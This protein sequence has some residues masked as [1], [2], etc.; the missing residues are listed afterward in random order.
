VFVLLVLSERLVVK[1]C[2]ASERDQLPVQEPGSQRLIGPNR[3]AQGQLQLTH[4]HTQTQTLTLFHLK[5]SSVRM[6]YE[7]R[8]YIYVNNATALINCAYYDK[9]HIFRFCNKSFS[10][11]CFVNKLRLG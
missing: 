2:R 9:V 1:Q 5:S 3:T 11:F 6:K 8:A 10:L 7:Y 4:T